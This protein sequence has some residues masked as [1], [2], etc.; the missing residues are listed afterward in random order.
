MASTS[1]P[2][3]WVRTTT[4]TTTIPYSWNGT[5]TAITGG[6]YSAPPP[7]MPTALEWLDAEV[8]SVCKLARAA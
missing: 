7:R 6:G 5:Y 8:E 3:Y 1:M 2:Q 4:N